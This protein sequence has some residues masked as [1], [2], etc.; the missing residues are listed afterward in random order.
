MERNTLSRLGLRA[1]RSSSRIWF[2]AAQS[3]SSVSDS[4]SALVSS[5]VRP[6]SCATRLTP[7]RSSGVSGTVSKLIV[8]GWPSAISV[9][10]PERTI[11]PACMISSRSASVSASSR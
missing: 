10:V 11:R 6:C 1:S 3:I 8:E 5:V 9:G 2:C 7:A 4:W